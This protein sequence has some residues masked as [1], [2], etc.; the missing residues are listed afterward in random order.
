LFSSS[1]IHLKRSVHSL[2][3]YLLF[4]CCIYTRAV[5]QLTPRLMG[6]ETTLHSSLYYTRG[7]KG[8]A[9]TRMDAH[10]RRPSSLRTVNCNRQSSRRL[11]WASEIIISNGAVDQFASQDMQHV[12]KRP[13]CVDVSL[14]DG[15]ALLLAC[16]DTM[17]YTD[18]ARINIRREMECCLR[19]C[20]ARQ[21]PILTYC[22]TARQHKTLLE[23]CGYHTLI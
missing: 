19:S 7:E 18:W 13:I 21:H 12:T 15:N 4:N 2:H 5:Y 16:Y 23:I 11:L 8:L 10:R 20:T 3:E 22:S 6:H 14:N 1:T 17:K 9:S